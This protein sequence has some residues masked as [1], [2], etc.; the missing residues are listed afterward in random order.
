[1]FP[2]SSIQP[3]RKKAAPSNAKRVQKVGEQQSKDIM[4]ELFNDLDDKDAEDLDETGAMHQ[5]VAQGA[6]G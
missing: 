3:N 5:P 6:N 4:N 1:M 2:V